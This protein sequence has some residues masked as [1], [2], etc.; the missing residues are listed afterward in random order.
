MITMEER[1]ERTRK[2]NG[3][4]RKRDAK[5]RLSE[6]KCQ[7]FP[8]GTQTDKKNQNRTNYVVH[9]LKKTCAAISTRK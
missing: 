8:E 1:E 2:G 5:E 4:R 3:E 9:V 7:R 6:R